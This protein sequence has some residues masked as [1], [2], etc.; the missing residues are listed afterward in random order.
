MGL[1]D[2]GDELGHGEL[3]RHQELG[4]VQRWEIFLPFV[5]LDDDLRFI[6]PGQSSGAS[7]TGPRRVRTL[8]G[9]LLG[10]LDRIPAT[11]C[12]L[13]AVDEEQCVT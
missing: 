4:F 11:S 13:V 1:P 8:T 6:E 12:F 9:I 10:N 7:G 3:V 5:A 2:D